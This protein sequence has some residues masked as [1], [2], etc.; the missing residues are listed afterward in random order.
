MPALNRYHNHHGLPRFL[1]SSVRS[2]GWMLGPRELRSDEPDPRRA[3]AG[4]LGLS[5]CRCYNCI[6][7]LCAKVSSKDKPPSLLCTSACNSS[8]TRMPY[9]HTSTLSLSHLYSS[10]RCHIRPYAHYISR[11]FSRAAMR[12]ALALMSATRSSRLY[13]ACFPL[14]GR[15]TCSTHR[16]SKE[17]PAAAPSHRGRGAPPWLASVVHSCMA[18]SPWRP[19]GTRNLTRHCPS[20]PPLKPEP[21]RSARVSVPA[22]QAVL[23]LRKSS[24]G[25]QATLTRMHGLTEENVRRM[26]LLSTG[27]SS[28]ADSSRLR[29]RGTLKLAT[30]IDAK[31]SAGMRLT[32]TKGDW[33]SLTQSV[34]RG[35]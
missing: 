7:R 16:M 15:G 23:P 1:A 11:I 10:R 28:V 30:P 17:R 12:S 6:I 8:G 26:L 27:T 13:A 4:S 21:P 35:R 24:R 34:P 14:I 3:R 25:A 18:P 29:F 2:N 5:S 33:R 32:D 22:G 20:G 31:L 9:A 19:T